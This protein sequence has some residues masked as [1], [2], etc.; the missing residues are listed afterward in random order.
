MQITLGYRERRLYK[1]A[2]QVD[3]SETRHECFSIEKIYALENFAPCEKQ[4]LI[5]QIQQLM[6][7]L[8]HEF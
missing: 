8:S 3:E 7:L 2:R 4:I 5:M 1:N 6:N